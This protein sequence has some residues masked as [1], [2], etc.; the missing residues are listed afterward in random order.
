MHS[1]CNL[2]GRV[3]AKRQAGT[4]LIFYDLRGEGKKI[5][6][7]A[8]AKYVTIIATVIFW[9]C[10]TSWH[11]KISY[12]ILLSVV[13]YFL[14]FRMLINGQKSKYFKSILYHML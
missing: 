3:H 12:N 7:M 10:V 5:Q 1:Y 2:T 13:P 9:L 11:C 14:L 6:I 4:K 8:N